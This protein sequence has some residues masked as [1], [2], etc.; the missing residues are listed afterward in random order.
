MVWSQILPTVQ[1]KYG[2]MADNAWL[3]LYAVGISNRVHTCRLCD[4]FSM[5][6]WF[7][8][9]V[10]SCYILY[11]VLYWLNAL[12]YLWVNYWIVSLSPLPKF[13]CLHRCGVCVWYIVAN[14]FASTSKTHTILPLIRISVLIARKS[15]TKNSLCRAQV[16]THPRTP[17]CMIFLTVIQ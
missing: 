13:A 3:I 14:V 12:R 11:V 15:G 17:D 10:H 5:T 8:A 7:S 16:P 1:Y 6:G 4:F 2:N 9:T